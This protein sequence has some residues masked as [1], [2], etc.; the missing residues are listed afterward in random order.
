MSKFHKITTF[1]LCACVCCMAMLHIECCLKQAIHIPT[2]LLLL[3]SFMDISLY[4]TLNSKVLGEV[5]DDTENC[6]KTR[7]KY[8][9]TTLI[10]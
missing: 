1:L 10:I 2:H 6:E 8:L 9:Y 3:L 5:N 7:C 4:R